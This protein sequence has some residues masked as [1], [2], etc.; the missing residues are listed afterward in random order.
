MAP[1]SELLSLNDLVSLVKASHTLAETIDYQTLLTTIL[2]TATELTDSP[3]GSIILHDPRRDSL[4]FAHAVGSKAPFL[5]EEFGE[6]A[7]RQ[8]P[9]ES[10]AGEVFRNRRSELLGNDSR[11][12]KGVDEATHK[13][14]ESMITVPLS[15]ARECIGVLQVLNKG[16]EYTERDRVFL[17]RFADQAGLA[18]RNANLIGDLLAHMGL[19]SRE[20]KKR[21][22]HELIKLL[23]A[24]PQSEEMSIMFVDL[25]G[26]RGLC[27]RVRPQKLTKMLD[28]FLSILVDRVL[29]HDGVVNKY[30]GDGI[31][32][33]F[34]GE[35]CEVNAVKAAFE[36]VDAF[37]PLKKSWMRETAEV[38]TFVDIGVG[39]CTDEATI[40]PVGSDEVKD[41]SVFGNVVNRAAAF[42]FDARGGK[43]VLVDQPTFNK[44]QDLYDAD[45]PVPHELRHPGQPGGH[46]YLQFHLRK[47]A[48]KP[49]AM[50]CFISLSS[51]DKTFAEQQIVN[52][53]EH[54]GIE[55]WIF[56][57][58]IYP[59]EQWPSAI[60]EG[61]KKSD[62]VIVLVSKNS[63]KSEWVHSE[64]NAAMSM[65]H[66]RRGRIIPVCIDESRPET[67]HL[68][69]G[70]IESTEVKE[71]AK[72]TQ[73]FT[74]MGPADKST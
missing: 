25:R 58:S 44:V 48:A 56:D 20:Q 71:L 13:K 53:L 14:T 63:V 10:K 3:D 64:V 60:A 17:E 50:T 33:F 1:L 21:S 45:E 55:P 54:K 59:G 23:S 61:L 62:F 9:W 70:A 47:K 6:R 37:E 42:E 30:L 4:Y 52:E 15:A 43:H 69:L 65:P 26:F 18:L 36:M 39:I 8:V 46:T 22:A 32:A 66:L 11:H 16:S 73:Q 34:R 38:I 35:N 51:E 12:F 57:S 74:K 19:Y 24:A 27:Q 2:E 28:Q 29:V 67:V 40:G 5:L 7:A 72:L 49:P 31:L 41:F 68:F